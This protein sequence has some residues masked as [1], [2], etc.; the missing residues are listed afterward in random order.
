MIRKLHLGGLVTNQICTFGEL[1]NSDEISNKINQLSGLPM[2][3]FETGAFKKMV[4]YELLQ[5]MLKMIFP[6]SINLW[7]D[8]KKERDTS[9]HLTLLKKSFRCE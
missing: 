2:R 5:K 1:K 3:K 9:H 6:S 4:V 8:Y 7:Q